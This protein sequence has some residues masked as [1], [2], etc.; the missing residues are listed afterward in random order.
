LCDLCIRS[1]AIF[2]HRRAPPALY[3]LSLHDALPISFTNRFSAKNT[4][5]LQEE[6]Y[7]TSVCARAPAPNDAGVSASRNRPTRKPA[8]A[9]TRSEEH[10]SEFQ[11]RFDPVCRL[12]PEKKKTSTTQKK[13]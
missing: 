6:R 3:T 13:T 8:A 4:A 11:S 1:F 10:T 7:P 5:L 2:F 9:L 12:P